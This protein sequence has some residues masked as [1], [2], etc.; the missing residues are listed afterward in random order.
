M[1]KHAHMLGGDGTQLLIIHIYTGAHK[2]ERKR[3]TQ[4]KQG[5]RESRTRVIHV[6][7]ELSHRVFLLKRSNNIIT[8]RAINWTEGAR[9]SRVRPKKFNLASSST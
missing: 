2:K 6:L 7:N 5:L 1:H 8:Y 9:S 4:E 3:H